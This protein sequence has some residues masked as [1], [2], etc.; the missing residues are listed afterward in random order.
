HI[1]LSI[2]AGEY[3]DFNKT[4]KYSRAIKYAK[5][6]GISGGGVVFHAFRIKKE[7]QRPI[8]QAIK[9]AGKKM[10]SWEGVRE[11]VL[12]L[13]SREDY[14]IF[15]PHFHI[16]G[17]FR[18]KQ[19]SSDFYK[20]TGW[21]YKNIS[22]SKGRGSEEQDGVFKIFAYILT[23]HYHESGKQA[24]HYFGSASKN[25]VSRETWKEKKCKKCTCGEQMYRIAIWSEE[26]VQQIQEGL[27]KIEL[28]EFNPKSKVIV[29][30]NRYRVRTSQ[31][32]VNTYYKDDQGG[33]SVCP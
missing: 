15:S 7:Y 33:G 31:A 32:T 24:I 22:W 29:I 2:P 10:G 27:H 23:H 26:R 25:K 17:Y 6:I 11:N 21:T 28:D 13:P 5:Q 30:H 20:E 12:G 19:K 14:L 1:E 18:L 16:V 8:Q 9:A 3:H 4:K